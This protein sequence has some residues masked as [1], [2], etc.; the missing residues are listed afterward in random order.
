MDYKS[1]IILGKEYKDTQTGLEGVAT[2][3]HFFQHACERVTIETV[4]RGKIEEYVFDAPR[5]SS[6][7]TG[8]KAE[9]PRP[10]GPGD[11]VRSASV[12]P[13]PRDLPRTVNK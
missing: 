1:D 9:S 6:K 10:G 5:L 2:A 4:V 12:R 11:G 7:E 8:V 13:L 3:I